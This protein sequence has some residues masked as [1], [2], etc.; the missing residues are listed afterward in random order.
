MSTAAAFRSLLR[1]SRSRRRYPS[2][3]TEIRSRDVP[4]LQPW[5]V[6][7]NL[8]S[9]FAVALFKVARDHATVAFITGRIELTR[10]SRREARTHEAITHRLDFNT[11]ESSTIE[12]TLFWFEKPKSKRRRTSS[13]S[14]RSLCFGPSCTPRDLRATRPTSLVARPLPGPLRSG[15]LRSRM[16]PRS[17]QP[18][19]HSRILTSCRVLRGCRTRV[20]RFRGVEVA[21]RRNILRRARASRYRCALQPCEV[22]RV[23]HRRTFSPARTAD[24][25]A[26]FCLMRDAVD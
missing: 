13:S 17:V 3:T 19:L 26:T 2:L 11:E 8:L 12:R 14:R 23:F 4:V 21:C 22:V 9:D 1:N 7:S 16:A 24:S 18:A 5:R 20:S 10:R 15:R 25:R 6:G